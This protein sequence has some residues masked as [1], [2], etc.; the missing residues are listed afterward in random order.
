MASLSVP[1][2]TTGSSRSNANERTDR[3]TLIV[4][5]SELALV[6]DRKPT[7]AEAWERFEEDYSPTR[8]SPSSIKCRIESAKYG[9]DTAVFAV[10][11]FFKNVE[12]QG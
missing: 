9:L 11:R 12:K 6:S 2:T 10:D 8:Q 3:Q 1:A 5:E 7:S 4:R